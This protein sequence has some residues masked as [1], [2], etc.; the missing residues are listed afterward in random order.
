MGEKKETRR[1]ASQ[2]TRNRKQA[3]EE[4]REGEKRRERDSHREAETERGRDR[5]RQ[6]RAGTRGQREQAARSAAGSPGQA[7]SPRQETP[8]PHEVPSAAGERSAHGRRP[9]PSAVTGSPHRPLAAWARTR[10]PLLAHTQTRKESCVSSESGREG[11][12]QPQTQNGERGTE[13][14]RKEGAREGSLR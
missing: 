8:A 12:H 13:R 1:K 5:D 11:M 10:T 2:L 9:V 6:R 3:R 7:P 4:A 14:S